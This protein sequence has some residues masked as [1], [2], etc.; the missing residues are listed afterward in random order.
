MPATRP[1]LFSPASSQ[2]SPETAP[3]AVPASIGKATYSKEQ[4][5]NFNTLLVNL[6]S[7]SQGLSAGRMR[8]RERGL[9]TET[10][11]RGAE[12]TTGRERFLSPG[13]QRQIRGARVGAT[14]A[15]RIGITAKRQELERKIENFPKFL[16]AF[17]DFAE[18]MK[19]KG[20]EFVS[21]T[22]KEDPAGNV[23]WVGITTDGR[24][25]QK[26]IGPI[27]K[28]FKGEGGAD[29]DW[30]D[31]R[32]IIDANPDAS[33]EALKAAIR[34]NTGL[35]VTD[36]NTVL[37]DA[38]IKKAIEAEVALSDNEL[39]ELTFTTLIENKGAPME[40]ILETWGTGS[41]LSTKQVNR[42]REIMEKDQ[43]SK[44]ILGDPDKYRITEKGVYE[45]K[46]T[47]F[48]KDKLIYKFEK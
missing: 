21:H 26:P 9:A 19:D 43:T 47:I 18:K 7:K 20:D 24:V 44:A 34:E 35:S 28:G 23:T 6:L 11:R 1:S 14:E 29:T 48:V 36:T 41:N 8:E 31:A 46:P 5:A 2:I 32:S 15:E 45:I 4:V 27:G 12:E 39:R 3:T 30:D 16:T 33:Y 10:L 42:M 25:V 38:G 37:A 13:Q 40:E 17:S 22:F